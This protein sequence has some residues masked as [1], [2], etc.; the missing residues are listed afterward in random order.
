MGREVDNTGM[1]PVQGQTTMV[2]PVTF[3]YSGG[4][5]DSKR[6][7]KIWSI[8]LSVVG[9]VVGIGIMFNKEGFFL[10]NI[11]LGLGLLYAILF[12]VRFFLLKEGRIRREE[13]IIRDKDFQDE[14]KNL[15]GIFNID[16]QYPYYCRFRNGKSGLFVRLN[17]DVILGKYS[18]SEFEHYEAIADAYNICGSS[19][20][21]LCH[22]DYMD[23]I[24]T[25]D[26]LEE[27]FISLAKVHNPDVKDLLT[28]I[29]SFQQQQMLERVTTF[30]A[31][32]F[33]WNGSDINA[34]STIQRILSCFMQANYR[35]YHILNE[36]DLRDLT[37]VLFNLNDFSVMSAMSTVFEVQ[38]NTGI[39][40]I[41]LTH[42]DGSEEIINK[43]T[44]EKKEEQELKRK[45]AE[46]IKEENKRRKE[47][48]R[49]NRR[50]KNASYEDD[51]EI[52]LFE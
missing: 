38:G 24:G 48:K 52:D 11:F 14:L 35:S 13:I 47:N 20:I 17:K 30:D 40:P 1:R 50:G 9:V 27:S 8:V 22:L 16:E 44:E 25:D 37:K 36:E 32:L 23:N 31:Y 5:R 45:E 19:N 7:A 29:Y 10:L 39:V 15:W 46:L 4:R 21:Q 49:Q 18:E 26:R 41:K 42:E 2:L 33:M 28:D 43:T 12:I 3:D 6:N 51:E 34:W